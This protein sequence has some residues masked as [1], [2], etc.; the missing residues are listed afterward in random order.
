MDPQSC[1]LGERPTPPYFFIPDGPVT[2]DVDP[3]L[4]DGWIAHC[5]AEVREI[6]GQAGRRVSILR[7]LAR[8]LLLGHADI[9]THLAPLLPIIRKM[10]AEKERISIADVGGGFG[11]NYGI[12]RTVLGAE[13]VGRMDYTVIDN[14]RSIALGRRLFP[15]C[16]F[17]EELPEGHFDIVV[18]VGTLQ[19]IPKWQN[20]L[21]A[22]KG[23]G[24]IVYVARS[25]LRKSGEGFE[26]KQAVCPA[27]GSHALEKCG[28]AN[29]W[30]VGREEL[31]AIFADWIPLIDKFHASYSSAFGRLPKEKRNVAYYVT[32]WAKRAG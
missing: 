21:H 24:D 30:V 31:Q 25:P 19:Y 26:V 3:W 11:D 12:L 28:I 22:L 14:A 1:Q 20:F 15:D 2:G 6:G 18:V 8:R 17:V 10:L 27:K 13:L 16:R 23:K 29:V 4:S 9:P 5:E 7:R 32:V